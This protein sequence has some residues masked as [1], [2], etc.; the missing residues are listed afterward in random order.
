M[1]HFLRLHTWAFR[2]FD[3]GPHVQCYVTDNFLILAKLVLSVV[4]TGPPLFVLVLGIIAPTLEISNKSSGSRAKTFCWFRFLLEWQEYF[5]S[6]FAKHFP[7]TI[8]STLCTRIMKKIIRQRKTEFSSRKVFT[9]IPAFFRGIFA[10]Q[11]RII[12]PPLQKNKHQN[13]TE[14]FHKLKFE[15][16]STST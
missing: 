6:N 5:Q 15:I 8:F 10:L 14:E 9:N 3:R 7:T 11:V 16:N 4:G 13:L 1:M 2:Y 12:A